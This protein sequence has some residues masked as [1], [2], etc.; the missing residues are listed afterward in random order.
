MQKTAIKTFLLSFSVSMLAI[1]VANRTF[2]YKKSSDVVAYDTGNKNISLFIK[3]L[4]S[5]NHP[6]KKINLTSLPSIDK[7]P[8]EFDDVQ[9]FNEGDIIVADE[10]EIPQ[11]NLADDY[12]KVTEA[13]D[14]KEQN[15]LLTADVVY[16]QDTP[17]DN[18]NVEKEIVYPRQVA[19]SEKA[20]VISE[21][22]EK[23]ELRFFDLEEIH[24]DDVAIPLTF[25]SGGESW[26]EV[27]IGNPS[28]LNHVALKSGNSV[29]IESMSNQDKDDVSV[30]GE[31]VNDSSKKYTIR[32]NPWV[33]AKINGVSKNKMLEKEF[34]D[35]NQEE[36]SQ[37]LK[38]SENVQG[39]KLASETV[40]NLIIPIPEKI[41]KKDNL[42]PKLAYPEDSPDAKKEKVMNVLSVK[43]EKQQLL[44]EI[45][46]ETEIPMTPIEDIKDTALDEP[47]KEE[48]KGLLTSISSMFSETVDKAK[49]EAASIKSKLKAKAKKNLKKKTKFKRVKAIIPKEIRMSFQ[50]NKAEISG[51][52]LRWVQAFASKTAK[53]QGT[54]LEVR[55]DRTRSVLLQ[56]RR[57]NLLYNILMNKGV[58]YSKIRV[59]FTDREPNTFILKMVNLTE[60]EK[61]ATKKI[62]KNSDMYMQW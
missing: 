27:S 48:K 33:I 11:N 58:E 56:Q 17:L 29:P 51:Q 10:I 50:N 46:E 6:I 23:E 24:R 28:D 9:A 45:E 52:T 2:L 26:A 12:V 40:K 42:L 19:L 43:K 18:K 44:T 21:S 55:I 32:D 4:S 13:E 36:I 15:G 59:V 1:A 5:N 20:P 38:T 39:V 37:A 7:A 47:K 31:A 34:A 14:V 57:L 61:Q 62:N 60:E 16:S 8:I 3:D 22:D 41:E 54:Y 49:N 53:E 30:G 25:G 35:V